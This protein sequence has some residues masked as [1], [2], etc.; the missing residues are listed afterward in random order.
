MFFRTGDELEFPD[1][2]CWREILGDEYLEIA[3]FYQELN[4][5]VDS[6]GVEMC[7][8]RI[9]KWYSEDEIISLCKIQ[10]K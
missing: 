2:I 1:I 6:G 4:I 3:Y 5:Y 9:E 10:K 8:Y 7:D